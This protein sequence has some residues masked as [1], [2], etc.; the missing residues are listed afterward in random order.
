MFVIIRQLLLVDAAVCAPIAAL[1][2]AQPVRLAQALE[3][4]AHLRVGELGR[5][6]EVVQHLALVHEREHAGDRVGLPRQERVAPP[7]EDRRGYYAQV[8]QDERGEDERH[9]E[10][11]HRL[12]AGAQPLLQKLAALVVVLFFHPVQDFE[13]V[14]ALDRGQARDE[15]GQGL[16]HDGAPAHE[17]DQPVPVEERAEGYHGEGHG[18]V[19]ESQRLSWRVA[20]REDVERLQH[21]DGCLKT[22]PG[23]LDANR[24]RGDDPRCLVCQ[25]TGWCE[26]ENRYETEE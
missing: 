15:D 17:E 7:D 25:R 23:Q 2:P 3:A 5:A 10:G 13:V 11:E 4:A 14:L 1:E 19:V 20:L 8:Q 18:R 6:Y 12:R 24:K 16:H 21:P 9:R 26:Q 22:T